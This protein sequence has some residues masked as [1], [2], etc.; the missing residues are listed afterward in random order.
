M[1]LL[2]PHQLSW[3]FLIGLFLTACDPMEMPEPKTP[4]RY[5]ALG[6]SY[7]IGE[8][9]PADENFPNQ[10]GT[11]LEAE[12]YPVDTVDI[13][14]QT[15]WRTFNLLSAIE[16][17]RPDSLYQY[18]LV[19]LLIGVNNQYGNVPFSTFETEFEELLD[20]AIA[21]AGGEKDRVLVLSIPDYAYTPFGQNF[22]PE[23]ISAE[24][25]MYNAHIQQVCTDRAVR[26]FNITPIS[27]QG[28]EQPDLVA[29]DGLHPS[30]KM[31]AAWVD[32][33]Q[34]EVLALLHD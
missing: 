30:G 3:L 33:F 6:D 32:L 8:S 20:R 28:L 21:F 7:T 24:L 27:Q 10:F 5:L 11:V 18:D 13:L 4:V 31:Y 26:F 34:E 12:G 14:A 19:S 22:N 1:L 15:G 25:E 23:E 29:A 17:Q 16:S 2:L 9:V